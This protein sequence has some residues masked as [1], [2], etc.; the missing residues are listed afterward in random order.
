[1]GAIIHFGTDGWRS[2]ADAD[3]TEANVARVACAAGIYWSRQAPGSTVYVGY[4]TRLGADFFARVAAEELGAHGLDVK[5]SDRYVPTPALSW[6][7]AQDPACCGGLMI[8]GSHNPMGYLGIKLRVADGAIGTADFY[9]EVEL[10]VP[11][12]APGHRGTCEFVDICTPY[13]ERLASLVDTRAIS[14]A[15]LK[16]VYDPMYGAASGYFSSLLVR[17]GVETAEIHQADETGWEDI[18]PEPIEPWVDA[19]ERAVTLCGANAGL[20]NDGD[21]D[22]VAAVDEN[23]RFV[24]QQKIIA[25]LLGHLVVDRGMTGRVVLNLSTSVLVRRIAAALGLRVVVKPVGFTHIYSVMQRG[26]VLIAA[27]EAGG[28]AIPELM[29]ERD[30]LLM[31]LL[32]LE[33]MAKTGKT[34]ATLVDEVEERFGACCFA[35]RDIR[36]AAEELE[37]LRTML[38]GVNPPEVAGRKP[39][40]VSHLDGL[41]LEFEDESW[42]LMRP[43]GTEP[44]VRVYAEA[45]S[46]EQRDEL[47]DAG[48]ELAR[49]GFI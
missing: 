30:G 7:V 45:Q 34:L 26:G 23:G 38:P 22:R 25:L 49:K 40:R 6:A 3:F 48:C 43:S 37:V 20:V 15:R 35:R 13:F 33:L 44:L 41:R 9:E 4:D 29:P 8:T 18:H 21:A 19:C 31:N 27:E 16:V 17:C 14:E 2:R 11:P 42:L 10:L 39:A 47:L 24:S 5:L 46:I 28:I 32:L 1:M 12:E 36:L